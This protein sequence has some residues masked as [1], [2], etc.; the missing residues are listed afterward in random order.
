[1]SVSLVEQMHRCKAK[2]PAT[3]DFRGFFF[4]DLLAPLSNTTKTSRLLRRSG[5]TNENH[6][7]SCSLLIIIIDN[8]LYVLNYLIQKHRIL[9]ANQGRSSSLQH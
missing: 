2:I 1:M 8:H 5:G 4:D 9:V 6:A 3:K 7:I